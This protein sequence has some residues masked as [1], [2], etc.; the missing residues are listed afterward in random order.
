MDRIVEKEEKKGEKKRRKE[1]D[2]WLFVKLFVLSRRYVK[3]TA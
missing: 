3:R 2:L 1:E